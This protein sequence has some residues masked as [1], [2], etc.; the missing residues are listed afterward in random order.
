M[1]R[2]RGELG[3]STGIVAGV[4]G[5]VALVLV[6]GSYVAHTVD[7]GSPRADAAEVSGAPGSRIVELTDDGAWSWLPDPRAVGHAGSPGLTYVGWVDA[8][9]DV[10]IASHDVGSDAIERTRLTD[11]LGGDDHS[12][13]SILV[14]PDGRV[15]AF[16]SAHG[17]EAVYSRTTSSPGDIA[18][19]DEPR[20]V[21]DVRP[22]AGRKWG[23]TYPNALRLP[24]EG[25]RIFVFF[26]GPDFKQW[27]VTSADGVNWSDEIP[28][29][30]GVG[31]KP[32]FKYA[33]DGTGTI[34]IAFTD[35][36]PRG[37]QTNSI[38]YMSYHR[39]AFQR[40]DGTL[41][42]GTEDL[43]FSP[44]DADTVYDGVS[45]GAPAW[46]A[47]VSVDGSGRPV[48]VYATFEASDDHRC[49]YAIW[50]GDQWSDHEITPTG[51][52]FA[53]RPARRRGPFGRPLDF[54]FGGAAI[55]PRDA[56]VVYVSRQVGETYEIER[57]KTADCG[58]T[59]AGLPVTGGS[60][61]HNVRPAVPRD[62]TT[63]APVVLWLTGTYD[64]YDS[65]DLA[66]RMLLPGDGGS[67]LE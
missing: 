1:K 48:V 64:D 7:S 24:D 31:A 63:G 23:Y 3:P 67:E 49:R 39:S 61:A 50:D 12:N 56:S 18:D 10:W 35:G 30:S 14:M 54:L 37:D 41:V 40:A 45:G 27:F 51:S 58:R 13:P 57:W 8:A 6:S 53:G 42:V 11:G 4:F 22:F 16:Y 60:E 52:S 29:M 17:G 59:W 38:Y 28:L 5:F 43:P 25:G 21:T 46:I 2:E 55:D 32:Y 15:T 34:H 26:R 66:V 19:W 33:S 65:Y 62:A 47:D 44:G 9:G 20:A 36:H